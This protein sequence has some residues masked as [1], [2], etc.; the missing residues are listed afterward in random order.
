[1]TAYN[2]KLRWDFIIKT[3][4]TATGRCSKLIV[5][6]SN[7]SILSHM[8]TYSSGWSQCWNDR[9]SLNEPPTVK[10]GSIGE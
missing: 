3:D 1:M 8:I 4:N 10:D 9:I 7:G 2:F 6:L 5:P